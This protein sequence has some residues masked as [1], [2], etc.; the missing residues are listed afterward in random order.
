[1]GAVVKPLF[2]V[3]PRPYCAHMDAVVGGS[4]QEREDAIGQLLAA[5]AAIHR[6]VLTLIDQHDAAESWREDGAADMA[7]W[8]QARFATDH[9]FLHEHRWQVDVSGHGPVWR[10]PDGSMYQPT[11]AP[12]RSRVRKRLVEPVLVATGS[13]PP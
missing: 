8:L 6:Q 2:L 9:R 4:P 1:M 13:G 12:L 11:S 3:T 5:M 10:R 7:G